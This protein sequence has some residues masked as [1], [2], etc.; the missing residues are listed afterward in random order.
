MYRARKIYKRKRSIE[1]RI[2]A[3]LCILLLF[4][5][6]PIFITT[7][8]GRMEVEDLLFNR[9]GTRESEVETRLPGIV[10]KQISIQM[11]EEVIKAQSVVARTQLLA[12]EKKGDTAPVGFRGSARGRSAYQ[13]RV[14]RH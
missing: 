4:G 7:F 3:I 1:E 6:L 14:V 12:A 8:F 13:P 11:P 9:P 5:V 10:A 2:N